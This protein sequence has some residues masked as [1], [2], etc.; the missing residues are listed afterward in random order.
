MFPFE[1]MFMGFHWFFLSPQSVVWC[2]IQYIW[3]DENSIPWNAAIRKRRW[4]EKQRRGKCIVPYCLLWTFAPSHVEFIASSVT[5]KHPCASRLLFHRSSSRL[6]LRCWNF[7]AQQLGNC[8]KLFKYSF[9]FFCF[10]E[11]EYFISFSKQWKR[12]NLLPNEIGTD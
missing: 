5:T 3:G 12:G 1:S 4:N 10:P 6:N 9:K 7:K 2:R 8:L 11:T